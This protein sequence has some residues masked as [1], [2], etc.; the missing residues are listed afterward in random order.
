[1]Y[2]LYLILCIIC[3]ILFTTLYYTFHAIL[4]LHYT[5]GDINNKPQLNCVFQSDD[6]QNEFLSNPKVVRYTLVYIYVY[7]M[8]Y[9]TSYL[10]VYIYNIYIQYIQCI[11]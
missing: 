4:H 11:L 1:M 5:T 8:A 3:T 10:L 2:T 6:A 7:C 9:Y